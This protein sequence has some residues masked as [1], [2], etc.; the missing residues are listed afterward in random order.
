MLKVQHGRDVERGL[1]WVQNGVRLNVAGHSVD[2]MCHGFSRV[3]VER[4]VVDNGAGVDSLVGT[5]REQALIP[6]DV[7]EIQVSQEVKMW[8]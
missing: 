1:A 3:R 6:V 5:E 2:D 8:G 4:A 7:P